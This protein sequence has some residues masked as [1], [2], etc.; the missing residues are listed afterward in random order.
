M[1]PARFKPLLFLPLC[2]CL[3]A[4]K[5]RAA[6]LQVRPGAVNQVSVVQ[7]GQV[8]A[9]Y[10]GPATAEW[11]LM[12]D[13]RRDAGW[14]LPRGAQTRVAAPQAAREHI[15]KPDQFWAAFV[16]NRFHDYAQQTTKVLA[17]PA[18]VAR[19]VKEGDVIEWR[20]LSWRVLDTPGFAR[21]SVSYVALLEGKTTVFTGDLIYSDGKILDLYSLQDAIPE[22]KVGGYHG[23]GGRLGD[24]IQ[25]LRKIRALKPDQLV[26]A[27]G[28]VI[29]DPLPA[30][31]RLIARLQALYKNYLST[32]A[33][34][35]YFKEERMR[36]CGERVLGDGAAVELM[37]YSLNIPAPDWVFNHSTSRLLISDDGHGFLLDC[38]YQRVIDAVKDLQAK[39]LV[40]KVEGIFVTH[41]H[42][43][44]SD[45]VQKA[46][47]V[48]GCPIY[49]TE[50]YADVLTNPGAYHLPALSFNAMKNLR[51]MKD[52]QKLA[53][54]GLNLTFHYYPGQM[55]HHGALLVEKKGHAPIFFIGDSFAPSGL[56]DY[57]LQN[58][59]LLHENSGYLYCLKK[60]GQLPEGCWLMNEHI[61]PL[62]RFSDK[63]RAHLEKRYRER[64]ALQRD[65]YPWDDPNYGVDEQWA[66]F[67][68]RVATAGTDRLATVELRVTNHSPKSR[69]FQLTPR[70][71][72]GAAVVGACDPLT[73]V[74]RQTGVRRVTVR[75]PAGIA[76]ALVTAGVQS[77]G[78][79]F[80][81]WVEALVVAP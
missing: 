39:N 14:S 4:L 50:E 53:W 78:M 44:H 18:A 58:R 23:Y 38:G 28:P 3:C 81:D 12:T 41:A 66:V 52:G 51:A 27:R 29:L 19:W 34:H 64:I 7:E 72:N 17:E 25:S 24:L 67:Y 43:D 21:G 16:T 6:V 32:N 54:R 56:D 31:D 45:M 55:L 9:V 26:P 80:R 10:G 40:K 57:C 47:E 15:E 48:F 36:L 2:L 69:T 1:N 65:L 5:G 75:L 35:W 49:A 22:A 13:A 62:F 70:A 61:A 74:S 76:R 77:P 71:W 73:V 79:E 42:D 30:I 33:L 8:L 20:G 11:L 37:P 63:E 68:P 60:L 46:S 59:N